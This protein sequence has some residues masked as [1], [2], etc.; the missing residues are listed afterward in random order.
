MAQSTS[1]CYRDRFVH[2]LVLKTVNNFQVDFLV[3]VR[4]SS[5]SGE[6]HSAALLQTRHS[7][8]FRRVFLCVCPLAVPLSFL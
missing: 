4:N 7:L 6:V 2:R 8:V 1:N 5:Y 3:V